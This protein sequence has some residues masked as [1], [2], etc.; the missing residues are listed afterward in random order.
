LSSLLRG[1]DIEDWD[2]SDVIGF[3]KEVQDVVHR[4]E[5]FM[6][7]KTDSHDLGSDIKHNLARLA[8]NRMSN[9]KQK[10]ESLVGKEQAENLIK[11][12]M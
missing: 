5:E 1:K 4:I 10:I 6:M 8:V 2:D 7:N 9:L 12:L 11:S 3:D